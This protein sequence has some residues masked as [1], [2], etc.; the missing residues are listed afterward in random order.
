MTYKRTES[1]HNQARAGEAQ[2]RPHAESEMISAEAGILEE[3]THAA[4]P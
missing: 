4:E 3:P 2:L 1:R